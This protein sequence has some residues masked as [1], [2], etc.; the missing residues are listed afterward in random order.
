MTTL[1]DLLAAVTRGSPRKAAIVEKSG[2]LS[3]LRLRQ[4]VLS[5]AGR[6]VGTGVKRGHRVALLLPNG[7]EFVTGFFAVAELGG[8][9]VPLELGALLIS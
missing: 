1:P 5:L 8:I 4:R 7:A 6:L 2:E 9:V 3:Y